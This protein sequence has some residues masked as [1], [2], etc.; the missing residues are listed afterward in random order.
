MNARRVPGYLVLEALRERELVVVYLAR[1]ELSGRLVTLETLSASLFPTRGRADCWIEQARGLRKLEHPHL[2]RVLDTG[3]NGVFWV[4]REWVPG[5]ALADLLGSEWRFEPAQALGIVSALADVLAYLHRSGRAHGAVTPS[6][7]LLS[8][9]GEVRLGGLGGLVS[10]DPREHAYLAPELAG[11]SCGRAADLFSLGKVLERVL[12]L[13]P[14]LD[15]ADGKHLQAETRALE[16]LVHALTAVDP[17]AR[18]RSTGA[19]ADTLRTV[20]TRLLPVPEPPPNQDEILDMAEAVS[21][22]GLP[23]TV[24]STREGRP[25]PAPAAAMPPVGFFGLLRSRLQRSG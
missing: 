21:E 8:T 2:V 1:H 23:L 13:T 10:L 16:A 4:V 20:H 14:P 18:P 7:I 5:M 25:R 11:G 22:L 6:N 3:R 24:Y 19:V 9:E 15:A 17:A 12:A